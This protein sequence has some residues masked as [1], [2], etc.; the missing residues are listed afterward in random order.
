[1][2]GELKLLIVPFSAPGYEEKFHLYSPIPS[3]SRETQTKDQWRVF[4]LCVWWCYM[5]VNPKNIRQCLTKTR[6]RACSNSLPLTDGGGVGRT[7]SPT[8]GTCKLGE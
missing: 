5:R 8:T 6:E 2:G 3:F 1:M 4:R 7:A